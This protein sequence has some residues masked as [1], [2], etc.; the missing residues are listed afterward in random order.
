MVGDTQAFRL[1]Q[2][3]K[4]I[5][6][7]ILKIEQIL[8]KVFPDKFENSSQGIQ[9]KKVKEGDIVV[10]VKCGL[11]FPNPQG[12]DPHMNNK[13]YCGKCYVEEFF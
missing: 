10:C 1:E 7:R 2:N 13:W 11:K 6:M 5:E 4:G 12:L 9:L 8:M 3:L